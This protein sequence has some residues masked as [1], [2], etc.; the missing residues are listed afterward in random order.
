[1]VAIIYLILA[2]WA[3]GKTIYANR[4]LIGTGKAIFAQKMAVALLIGWLLIPVAILKLI[5]G[6]H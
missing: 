4:I 2:Y 5:F 1:M 3:V 6:R